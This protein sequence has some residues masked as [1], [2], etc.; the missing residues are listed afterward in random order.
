MKRSEERKRAA[1]CR[2]G[3]LRSLRD[4]GN[5]PTSVDVVLGLC[6]AYEA[7]LTADA[8]L[9]GDDEDEP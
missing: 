5:G 8:L 3:V 1:E 7:M 2:R 9:A 6:Q 4:A